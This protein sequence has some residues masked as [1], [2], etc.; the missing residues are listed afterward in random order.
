MNKK[1]VAFGLLALF[2]IL[3][4]GLR[5][6]F[7]EVPHRS[8]DEG[9]YTLYAAAIA[10]DGFIGAQRAVKEY[11]ANPAFWIYPP[12]TRVGHLFLLAGTMDFVGSTDAM[13]GAYLS[14]F[15]SFLSLLLLV[16]V[17]HRFFGPWVSVAALGF[18]ATSPIELVIARRAWQDGV[19]GFFGALLIYLSAELIV[20][21]EKWPWIAAHALCGFYCVLIKESGFVIYGI[22]VFWVSAYFLF[23][24]KKIR[25]ALVVGFVSLGT[26]LGAFQVIAG[27]TGGW[28]GLFEMARHIK[29]AMPTNEYAV[30]YQEAPWYFFI[31]G[32]W[33]LSPVP[34]ALALLGM[35]VVLVRARRSPRTKHLNVLFGF[36]FVIILFTSAAAIP[37]YLKNLRYISPLYVSIYLFAGYGLVSI[38]SLVRAKSHK[39]VF[40]GALVIALLGMGVSAIRDDRQFQKV[41][42]EH[43]LNDLSSGYLRMELPKMV[44]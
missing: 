18:M 6:R 20:R 44:G 3:G 15:F 33:I 25:E 40:A 9:I 11:I 16:W 10:N 4:V 36:I 27:I 23:K 34:A 28:G 39:M 42:I 5:Y 22:C 37:H 41:F 19:M 8:P 26:L 1:R 43:E 35:S 21:K 7:F 29:E 13:A 2:F 17:G 38:L 31:Q 30:V 32:F 14:R 24:E 12:P